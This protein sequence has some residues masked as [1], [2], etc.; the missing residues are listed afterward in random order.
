MRV[1]AA[2]LLP[3]AA[4]C[5]LT[6]LTS[7]N[8]DGRELRPARADQT[9]SVSTLP[10]AETTGA[11]DGI[12]EI[13]PEATLPTLVLPWADGGAIDA[14]YTCDGEGVAPAMSWTVPPA[15]TI[16]VAVAV[17]DLDATGF[18][19]WAMSGLGPLTTALREGEVPEGATVAVNDAG[20]EGWTPPC[21]PPGETH[22]YQ[23]TLYFLDQQTELGPGASGDDLLAF[24]KGSA[25][26][27]RTILG[28][29]TREAG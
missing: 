23:F 28:T 4:A 12:D 27:A 19:H 16:E 24:I 2:A 21:P 15:R 6:T 8:D 1:R 25:F 17:I 7:C 20:T 13:E 5:L 11:L 22:T 29:Y 26:M 9:A 3:A 10:E 14:R 18:V